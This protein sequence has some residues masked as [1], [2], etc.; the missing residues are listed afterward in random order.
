MI[1]N[2]GEYFVGYWKNDKVTEET[3]F[4]A[5]G[6]TWI[7]TGD[8]GYVTEEGYFYISGRLKR[9]LCVTGEDEVP[10]RVYPMEVERVLG[11][12]E[13]VSD[14]AVVGRKSSMNGYTVIA[15]LILKKESHMQDNA[16]IIEELNELCKRELPEHSLPKEFH[17]MEEFPKTIAGKT[18][19]R[20]LEKMSNN[21]TN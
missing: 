10:F 20:K 16:Q 7:H 14:C 11:M 9:I 5:K 13:E 1:K 4:Q 17:I 19:F 8:L 21:K 6:T 12:H 15:F 3:L 2:S 18:D